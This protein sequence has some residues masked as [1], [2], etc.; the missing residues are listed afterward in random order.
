ML[1]IDAEGGRSMK[2]I[3]DAWTR[4]LLMLAFDFWR[5]PDA[6]KKERDSEPG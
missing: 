2:Q 1:R 3:L 4:W 6:A 5:Y